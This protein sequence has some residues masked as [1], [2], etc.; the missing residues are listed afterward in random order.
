MSNI[1]LSVHFKDEVLVFNW[2]DWS[3]HRF[4]GWS[5]TCRWST[6]WH[7]C[8]LKTQKAVCLDKYFVVTYFILASME[9]KA[10]GTAGAQFVEVYGTC[11]RL[12]SL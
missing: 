3:V 9:D 4:L 2:F 8:L 10:N 12:I 11:A 1:C 5:V 6:D 7:E